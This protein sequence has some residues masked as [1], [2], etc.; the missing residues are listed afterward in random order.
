M[1]IQALGERIA[2]VNDILCSLGVLVWDSRTMMPS[3]GAVSRGFQIA[4]LTRTARDLLASDDTLRLVESAEREA[5]KLPADALDREAV[6]QVRE[7]VEAHRRVPGDVIERRAAVRA[8]AN[9]AWIEARARDDFSTFRPYLQ[10]TVA[11]TREYADALGWT[12]HRYDA[13]LRLYEPGETL[14]RLRRLFAELRAGLKPILAAARA[15]PNGAGA[16]L[17]RT[18]PVETQRD[19]ALGLARTLGYDLSRGRLDGT[20]HPFEISFTREDVRITTRYNETFLRPALF[21]AMHETGHALYEQNVDPAFSRT[22]FATDLLGLYAVGGTSFGA[23]ESQSRL[24]ENHVGRSLAFWRLQ[25]PALKERFPEALG[26]VTAERFYEAVTTVEPG[27]IRTDADELTYDFH[28]MLRVDIEAALIGGEM[29]VDDVPEAW[30]KAMKDGLGLDVPND[31]LG[32]LQDIHWSSGMIGSFCT[33]TIG[34]VMAA[35]LFEAALASDDAIAAGLEKGDYAPLAGWLR[36]NVWRHGRSRSREQIL[37]AAT[38]RG[39]ETGP[40]LRYL[41]GKYGA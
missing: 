17:H 1:T 19:V 39:L 27:L 23:H 40:Y 37:V 35:Q 5:A 33:Y 41:A 38:G 20:V 25:F 16:I 29:E 8:R 15:R 3:G 14:E 34:N 18:F 32:C 13:L 12:G 26:D 22:V 28:I 31:R 21:G 7:A 30:R 9:A 2:T 6:R 11:N 10:E 24:W 36:E 4:T